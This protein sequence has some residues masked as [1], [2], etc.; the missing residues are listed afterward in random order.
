MRRNPFADD[1]RP[2]PTHALEYFT[3]REGFIQSF[4]RHLDT[5]TGQDLSILVFY[6]VGGIGKTT[7]VRKLCADLMQSTS[8]LPHARFNLENVG[9]QAQACRDV[10]LRLRSDL[11][12]DF[13]VQFPR[14]DL[15]LAVLLAREGGE[16]PPL[17]RMSPGLGAAF[18]AALEFTPSFIKAGLK[19][20]SQQIESA[21]QRSETLEHW[22]RQVGGTEAVL[23]LNERFA[24]D[25]QIVLE[26][27][28]RRFAQDLA[29]SLLERPGKA[30]RGVLFLD[31]YEALW[32]G[33]ESSL[34]AQARLL[35]AWVRLLAEYLLGAGVLLVIAGR[36][37]LGWG[38]G[39]PEWEACLDQHILG[40]VSIPDAQTF[41]A[42]RGI[43][44]PPPATPDPLQTSILHCAGTSAGPG[45]P[46]GC[47][48]LAMALSADIV[49]NTRAAGGDPVPALFAGVPPA[50]LAGE[51]ATRFLKSLHNRNLELWVE[52]LSLTPRFDEAAALALD[53]ERQLHAGRAGWEQLRQYSFVTAQPDGFFRMHRTMREVLRARSSE[54]VTQTLQ[55]WFAG[56]WQAR[57]ETGLAFYHCWSRDPEGQ[58][59]AWNA[60]HSAALAAGRTA[61][62]RALIPD[63]A[64]VALD[65]DD[66]SLLSDAAWAGDALC[67]GRGPAKNADF[68]SVR[69][70]DGSLAAFSIRPECLDGNEPPRKMG[71]GA[72]EPGPD[73]SKLAVGRP[74]AKPAASRSLFPGG[75]ARLDGNRASA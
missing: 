15:A 13:S 48:L 68:S 43:G 70:A 67:L 2:A 46:S 71:A 23:E 61:D 25:D 34:A 21:V 37:R 60:Q 47:H 62:A 29:G 36:D 5:P 42:R 59:D 45:Q 50:K 57:G 54:A 16:H 19:L 52:A 28:V 10:L 7:L 32:T 49:Q 58:R 11:E 53:A 12:S 44:S 65:D 20:A 18:G 66:R 6:G 38:D 30:C 74:D 35:D 69:P 63:W 56:Y 72:G 39:D 31:T 9:D 75:P 1:Q 73:L 14:F 33:R 41:L 24:Q 64:E 40:G 3:N 51:L 26:E 8:P 27:L 55:D 17:V 4:T 22:V